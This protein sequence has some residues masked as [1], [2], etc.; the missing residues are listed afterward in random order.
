MPAQ[1][2]QKDKKFRVRALLKCTYHILYHRKK[3]I[4]SSIPLKEKI[5]LSLQNEHRNQKVIN[6][7]TIWLHQ[8]L[9]RNSQ[10]KKIIF[11]KWCLV[12]AQVY[13]RNQKTGW[14][15]TNI[16]L[17]L[18]KSSIRPCL[19]TQFFTGL[20]LKTWQSHF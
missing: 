2:S 12:H 13:L 16:C 4:H 10:S 17:K 8:R 1:G 19:E 5:N 3:I 20:N 6:Y 18:I 11:L 15:S 9:I 14:I 7:Q